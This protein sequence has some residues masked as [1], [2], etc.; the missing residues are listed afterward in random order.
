MDSKAKKVR[1][2][3]DDVYIPKKTV[4]VNIVASY[5]ANGRLVVKCIIN[6]EPMSFNFPVSYA[7]DRKK[8]MLE[9]KMH[10]INLKDNLNKG[11]VTQRTDLVGK[12]TV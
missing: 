5:T 8:L 2:A 10:Y 4:E 1:V 3:K 11:K 6:G 7:K 12:E 9:I